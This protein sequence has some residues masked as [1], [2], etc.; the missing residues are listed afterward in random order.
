[1]SVIVFFSVESQYKLAS[2]IEIK[3]NELDVSGYD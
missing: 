2:N 3:K 1:M